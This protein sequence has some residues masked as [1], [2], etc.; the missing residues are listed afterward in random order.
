MKVYGKA[1]KSSPKPYIPYVY[2]EGVNNCE[3]PPL[4]F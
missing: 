4:Q 2:W 3:Y 1:K